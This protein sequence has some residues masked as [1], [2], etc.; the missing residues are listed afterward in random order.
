MKKVHLMW[1]LKEGLELHTPTY[2]RG[3]TSMLL[4]G[5]LAPK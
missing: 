4:T 1:P 3:G 2:L 5:S